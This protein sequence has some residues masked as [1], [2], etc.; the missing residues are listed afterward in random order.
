MLGFLAVLLLGFSAL[1]WEVILGSRNGFYGF[2]GLLVGVVGTACFLG[3]VVD[4][5]VRLLGDGVK[6]SVAGVADSIGVVVEGVAAS[7]AFPVS[8]AE[9]T[10][11]GHN[12]AE[13]L[14]VTHW[15][16]VPQWDGFGDMV[17]DPTDWDFP[18]VGD[19]HDGVAM[20]SP[21]ADLLAEIGRMG[22]RPGGV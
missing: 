16:Q 21:G 1:I 12:A 4:R 15:Q 19:S 10:Q 18:D 7:V 9:V 22:N 11:P 2:L 20:I 17:P 3:F 13:D 5:V 8:G 6:D 14:G